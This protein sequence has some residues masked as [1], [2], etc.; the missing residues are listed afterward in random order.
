MRAIPRRL[1]GIINKVAF[2]EQLGSRHWE[3]MNW[4]LYVAIVVQNGAN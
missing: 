2:S 4:S 3:D 1:A